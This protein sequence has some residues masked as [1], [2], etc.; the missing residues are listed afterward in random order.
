MKSLNTKNIAIVSKFLKGNRLK[1]FLESVN[2]YQA[3]LAAGGW[4]PK[5]SISADKGFG[6]GCGVNIECDSSGHMSK[7][8][9]VRARYEIDW[10][11]RSGYTSPT[12]Y[13]MKLVA[14]DLSAEERKKVSPEFLIAWCSLCVEKKAA[15]HFLDSLR[16]LPVITAIG[17]SPKVTKTLKDMNLDIDLPSIKLAKIDYRYVPKRHNDP[18]SK[19][20]GKIMISTTDNDSEY[21]VLDTIPFINWTKGI[22]HGQSR[23]THTTGHCEACGKNI[24]SWRFVAIEAKDKKSNRLVSFLLGCDCAKN[25]FGIKDVGVDLKTKA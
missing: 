1:K 14:D 16:P 6:Q 10:C 7:S 15:R 24:P 20:F 8:E 5:M 3:S 11:L 23:F 22:V 4:L 9:V 25:I 18:K 2:C 19:N 13:E 17:L 12:Y 21:C